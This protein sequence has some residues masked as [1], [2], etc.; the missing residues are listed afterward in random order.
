MSV[1]YVPVFSM[2]G[3]W[4]S[5][6]SPWVKQLMEDFANNAVRQITVLCAAQAAK[7]ETML[8]LLNWIIAEDASPTMWDDIAN[9]K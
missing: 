4:R 5:D 9:M 6:N 8:A 2:P 3:R 1:Y 7:T